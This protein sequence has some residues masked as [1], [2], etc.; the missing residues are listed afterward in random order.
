MGLFLFL[1]VVVCIVYPLFS[2][3]NH[4]GKNSQVLTEEDDF[5]GGST[6]S[7]FL[8]ED[9]LDSG[10]GKQVSADQGLSQSE[11]IEDEYL[12]DEFFE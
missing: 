12:E 10:A 7:F 1:M 2:R 4:K 6:S 3:K 5:N 11:Q 9:I 8:L